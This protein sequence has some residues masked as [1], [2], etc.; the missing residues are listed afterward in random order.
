MRQWFAGASAL[1]GLTITEALRERLWL[2]FVAAV[3]VLVLQAPGLRAVDEGARLKLAVVA[4]TGAIGFVTTL[5]AV[6]VA[7]TALRRDLDART[8]YLLFAKP[9]ARSAYLCGR[10]AG[11][12]GGLLLGIGALCLVGTATIA[13][14]FHGLPAMRQVRVASDWQQ[15]SAYGQTSAVDES[16]SRIQLGG[17]AGNGVRWRFSGLPTSAIPAA[18]IEVLVRVGVH[19]FDPM[20]AVDEALVQVTALPPDDGKEPG[21]ARIPRVLALDPASPYGRSRGGAAVPEGQAVVRDHDESRTDLSQDYLR[22]RLPADCVGADGRAELQLTRLEARAALVVGKLTSIKLAVPGGSFFANL[23]RGGL[24]SLAAASLLVAWTLVCAAVSNLGVTALGGLTLYFAGNALPAMRE[25]LGY[26]DAGLSEKR[27]LELAIAV[28][29][30][31]ERFGV[32]ARL[33]ASEAIDWGTVGAAWIYYGV[34]ATLFLALAWTAMARR[35][36]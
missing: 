12:Q 1:A 21:K 17:A 6:L 15:V 32:A 28:L 19:G 13:W 5:L 7:A 14:Q 22:L 10:W 31:F 30:D 11:V 4:I 36:M 23:A 16:R 25:V 8:G 35:E 9:L 2:L 20:L 24:V 33:A 34:Y 3:A 27:L 29:P 26:N 18:G